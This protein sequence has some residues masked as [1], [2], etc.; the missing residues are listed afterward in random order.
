LELKK[1]GKGVVVS[2]VSFMLHQNMKSQY[3][4]LALPD[5]TI[6]WKQ[7]WWFYLDNPRRR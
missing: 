5:N 3:I 2:S 7:G 1:T 6:G 4:H